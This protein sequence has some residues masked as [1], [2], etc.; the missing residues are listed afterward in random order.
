MKFM[1]TDVRS[2]EKESGNPL[3]DLDLYKFKKD[4]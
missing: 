1:L 2:K 3:Q 4:C